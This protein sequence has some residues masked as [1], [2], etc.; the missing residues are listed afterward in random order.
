MSFSSFSRE[1][2]AE[3]RSWMDGSF[4]DDEKRVQYVFFFGAVKREQMEEATCRYQ[5]LSFLAL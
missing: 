1:T 2:Q 3:I 5:S 4:L